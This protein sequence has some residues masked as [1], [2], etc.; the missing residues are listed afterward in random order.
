MLKTSPFFLLLLLLPTIL[1]AQSWENCRGISSDR[2]RLDCYDQYAEN[3]SQQKTKPTEE[4]Q[5]AAFGLPKTSP[6][7]DI[8]AISARITQIETFS[9]GSRLLYLD[10][11]Q[12]WRQVGNSS[13]PKLRNGDMIRIKR[14]ALG[15]FVLK[16]ADSNRSMR[17]KRFK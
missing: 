5:K 16:K 15:S 12:V 14:G 13:Q 8:G 11:Q 1:M 17:V 3:L 10:N 9:R 7:D 6:A 4:D 2:D